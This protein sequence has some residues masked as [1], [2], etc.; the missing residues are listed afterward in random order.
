VNEDHTVAIHEAAHA[1]AAIRAGLIFDHVTALPDEQELTD[2]SLH[3]SELQAS[4]EIEVSPD[5][6]AVVLLAG[7]CAEA[8]VTQRDVE[9]VFTGE[10]AADDRE[11][12]AAL[13][14]DADRFVAASVEALAL[15]ERDWHLIERIAN[16]LLEVDEL[17]YETVES[18][19]L[20]RNH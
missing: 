15:I 3:W 14:L 1:V 5:L 16:E 10:E 19:V 8:R 2:G 12:L 20:A 4:G 17:D 13:M 7:P 6:L 9:D 11:A 18:L